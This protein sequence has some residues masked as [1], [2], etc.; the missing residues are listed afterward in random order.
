[1]EQM[2]PVKAI[3]TFFEANGGRE[4]KLAELKALSVEERLELG[5]LCVVELG[6]TLA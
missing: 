6:V 4:V 3:K 2:S 1:M 5:K